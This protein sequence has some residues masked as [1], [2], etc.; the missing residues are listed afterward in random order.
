MFQFQCSCGFRLFYMYVPV[1]RLRTRFFL[2]TTACVYLPVGK[3]LCTECPFESVRVMREIENP[4][5]PRC[6]I[7]TNLESRS[8]GLHRDPS[9]R[10]SLTEAHDTAKAGPSC[11]RI[12]QIIFNRRGS[13]HPLMSLCTLCLHGPSWPSFKPRMIMCPN[14]INYNEVTASFNRYCVLF[15]PV[16]VSHELVVPLKVDREAAR[17]TVFYDW[18]PDIRC[19]APRRSTKV[20]TLIS[21]PRPPLRLVTGLKAQHTQLGLGLGSPLLPAVARDRLVSFT[22]VSSDGVSVV[23][24]HAKFPPIKP[25]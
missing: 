25:P 2:R 14:Q 19:I 17:L 20:Q 13:P 5:D 11:S 21:I 18:S 22:S 10:L 9:V 24:R 3:C 23:I 12:I 1:A 8:V 15:S 7:L 4:D 6:P 16:S